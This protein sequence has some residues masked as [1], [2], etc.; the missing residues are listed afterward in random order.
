MLKGRQVIWWLLRGYQLSFSAF[1]GRQC[2][3]EPTCSHYM[4]EAVLRFGVFKGLILGIKRLSRCHPWGGWGFDPV[5][6]TLYTDTHMCGC[7][8]NHP[9]PE[10]QTKPRKATGPATGPQHSTK[11]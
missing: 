3:F 8:H 1:L 10:L 9:A 6:E 2:R 11:R 5:P 7:G 4:Q